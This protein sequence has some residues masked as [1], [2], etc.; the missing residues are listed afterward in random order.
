M[1]S[2]CWRIGLLSVCWWSDPLALQ[3]G[4]VKLKFASLLR[5][6]ASRP[7]TAVFSV[8]IRWE[9]R[10]LRG[11]W[12]CF[13]WSWHAELRNGNRSPRVGTLKVRASCDF[14]QSVNVCHK[15]VFSKAFWILYLFV[16]C[17]H[18]CLSS[19]QHIHSKTCS[20]L[21]QVLDN[22]KFAIV[23]QVKDLL[24]NDHA[25]VLPEYNR[26]V[27]LASGCQLQWC[28]TKSTSTS[29]RHISKCWVS[30]GSVSL[31]HLWTFGRCNS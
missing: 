19:G 5:V 11:F 14:P 7:F 16:P 30:D 10:G 15:G 26:Y 28:N 17:W 6:P 9:G 4:K 31:W 24:V 8:F 23:S 12:S 18:K 25:S 13:A 29:R 21:T 22:W 3:K 20:N 27:T 1:F 2:H